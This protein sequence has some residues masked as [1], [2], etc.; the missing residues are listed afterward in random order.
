M[1][2]FVCCIV[3]CK[4]LLDHLLSLVLLFHLVEKFINGV[5]PE[6]RSKVFLM[7]SVNS[8]FFFSTRI[9][10]CRYFVFPNAM[11]LVF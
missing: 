11:Y 2:Y 6:T 5:L 9:A 8:S 1:I 7:S 3:V 10:Y 4:L